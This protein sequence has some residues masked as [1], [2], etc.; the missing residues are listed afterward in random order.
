MFYRM[1]IRIPCLFYK[2]Y[3][4]ISKITE[5]GKGSSFKLTV[6]LKVVTV[7]S[8]DRDCIIRNCILSLMQS[9]LCEIAFA[10]LA[11]GSGSK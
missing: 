7:I 4:S 8:S 11:G 6:W 10:E 9:I 2:Q 3:F 1:P 5:N